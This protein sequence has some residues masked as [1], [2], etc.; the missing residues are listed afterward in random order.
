[1]WPWFLNWLQFLSNAA[2]MTEP[3]SAFAGQNSGSSPAAGIPFFLFLK[4]E[5]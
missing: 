3:G 5:P 4:G 2:N 1:M